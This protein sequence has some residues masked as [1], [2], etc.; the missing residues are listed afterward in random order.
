MTRTGSNAHRGNM[1]EI[2]WVEVKKNYETSMF[3]RKKE[4]CFSHLY[5]P[6]SEIICY[7]DCVFLWTLEIKSSFFMIWNKHPQIVN[8][9]YNQWGEFGILYLDVTKQWCASTFF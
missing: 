2:Q 4:T 8:L 5:V 6:D 9:N 7:N 1:Q 3:C